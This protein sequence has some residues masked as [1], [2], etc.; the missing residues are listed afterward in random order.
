MAGSGMVGSTTAVSA[1]GVPMR[2]SLVVL[3][4]GLLACDLSMEPGQGDPDAPAAA[5]DGAPPHQDAPPIPD[6]APPIED[7]GPEDAGRGDAGTDGG[8]GDGGADDGGIDP[9]A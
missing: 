5:P 1:T 4:F 6:A 8:L 9:D 7:A 2:P 3:L